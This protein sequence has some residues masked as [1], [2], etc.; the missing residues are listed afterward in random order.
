V[1]TPAERAAAAEK[2]V[3]ERHVRRLW[4]LPGTALGRSGWPPSAGQRVHWHWN[5]WW[6][7][8]LLDCLVDAQLRAPSPERARLIGRF[9]STMKVRNF[10]SWVNEYYDDIAWLGL[11]L[12]RVEKVVGLDVGTP[13][14]AID[15]RL[16]EGW[17]DEAGG[18]IWWRRGERFKNVPA[19]GPAAIFHARAGDVGYAHGLTKWMSEHLVDPETGLVWDGLRVDSGEIVKMI[20]TYCQGVYLGSCLEV[21]DVD[22]AQRTITAVAEHCAP[23]GV[24]RGQ[25][26]G[27][28]GLFAGILAR[29]LA[30]AA[31]KLPPGD[32]AT[33]ART[34]VLDSA[35]ACWANTTNTA[36]GPQFSAEWSI[37]P[38]D[39]ARDLSVQVGA[40]LL[41]EAAATLA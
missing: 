21:S 26:D 38:D 15:A 11:A 33:A 7:S 14:A 13:L 16:R 18:G 10:G 34:L 40:W 24:I 22:S 29:Y 28:G 25:G 8:H 9:A 12:Q 35:D 37:P 41:L 4:G 23:G 19:N 1:V 17:T 3:V 39:H 20:Y 5:Y 32:A 30:L 6:Q 2:A 31:L 27:D 36:Q